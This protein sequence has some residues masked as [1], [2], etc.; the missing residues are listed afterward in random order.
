MKTLLLILLLVPMM[1]FISCNNSPENDTI[2]T[3]INEMN[4]VSV[5][6]MEEIISNQ[7]IIE[8]PSYKD[9]NLEELKSNCDCIM[10]SAIKSKELFLLNPPEY[11]RESEGG[12]EKYIEYTNNYNSFMEWVKEEADICNK[13]FQSTEFIPEYKCDYKN[14][15]LFWNE[16]Q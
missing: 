12:G 1:S 14:T 4:E 2:N 9:V 13:I 15:L 5:E 8:L 3:I 10:T 6:E 11:D 7:P 16:K